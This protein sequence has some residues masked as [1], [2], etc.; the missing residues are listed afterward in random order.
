[1]EAEEAAGSSVEGEGGEGRGEAG[2]PWSTLL[3]VKL[4]SRIRREVGAEEER[5][6]MELEEGGGVISKELGVEDGT[7]GG[8]FIFMG[9]EEGMFWE[10]MKG[11][12]FGERLGR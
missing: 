1:M 4:P 11:L 2:A 6:E 5:R 3:V 10:A 9:G 12:W 7:E 8:A